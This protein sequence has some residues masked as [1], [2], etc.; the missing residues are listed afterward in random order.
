M[1]RTS[2]IMVKIFGG[3]IGITLIATVLL[4][5]TLLK[6]HE[7]AI[8]SSDINET[9][10]PL[11]QDTNMV[12]KNS[13][14][15]VAALRGY[16]LTEDESFVEQFTQLTDETDKIYENLLSSS[17][18]EEGR[19]LT[20]EVK[21]LE[22]AYVL[23]ATDNLIPAVKAGNKD[24]ALDIMKNQMVPAAAALQVK[25]AEYQERRY[26]QMSGKLDS[27]SNT[28]K[29]TERMIII[30][31]IVFF[32]IAIMM[33][34]LISRMIIK[35]IKIMQKGL[36][37]AERNND[38]T[39]Q[40]HVKS[41][42]EIGA[43]A[44]ALN[45]FIEKIRNSFHGVS[46][47][48]TLVDDSVNSVN[49]N[50][51][52]LNGY[53]EDISATTEELS[54]GMEETS[55]STEEVTATVEEINI[56]VQNVSQKAQDGAVTVD[57]INKRAVALRGDFEK[58]QKDAHNVR[59]QVQEKLEKSLEESKAV[60]KINEL[61]NG[62]L[63]IASQTN[64]LALNAS[65]EAARAGD[66]GRGFAVVAGEIGKLAEESTRTVNQIQQINQQVFNAVAN[67]SENAKELMQF[68]SVNVANDYKKML[69]A[70][71]D[72]T[73]DANKVDDIVTELSSTSQELLASVENITSA[74]TGVATAT[75]EGAEGI[76]NIAGRASESALESN[77]TVAD[78][79]KVK[80]AVHSLVTAV[81]IFKI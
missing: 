66:A 49:E 15:E 57:E 55:A 58:S 12:I 25:M 35:P 34:L 5:F 33:S 75:N 65:I 38:L 59:L 52:R 46:D 54:A 62:I 22:D 4:I 26:Q 11:Y 61:A 24:E 28:A 10:L 71:N 20:E 2:S 27:S 18:T 9:Y 44:D 7:M 53:I 64:L 42:D 70:T 48:A 60:D 67:L 17:T 13:V 19:K 47:S 72:Y 32:V 3:F 74:I 43:M 77:K 8:T 76:T 21:G 63:N 50:I 23:I 80:E 68:V 6:I 45:N 16:V 40:I 41:N 56:A 36:Q 30:A 78:T 73:N 37:D 51:N 14:K 69:L 1:K 39:C 79:G 81:R 31:A 29:M